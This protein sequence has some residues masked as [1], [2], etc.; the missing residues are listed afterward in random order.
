MAVSETPQTQMAT[1]D[2]LCMH[3]PHDGEGSRYW[4]LS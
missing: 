4:H 2:K 1:E 3:F